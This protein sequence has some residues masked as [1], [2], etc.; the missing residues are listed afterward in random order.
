MGD[1]C[2]ATGRGDP[3]SFHETIAGSGW[4]PIALAERAVL[5]D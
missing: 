5:A 1:D 2:I 3:R 4:F